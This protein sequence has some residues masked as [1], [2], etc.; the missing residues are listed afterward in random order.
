M[1]TSRYFDAFGAN[2]RIDTDIEIVAS[3]ED[4]N[5]YIEKCIQE[6]PRLARWVTSDI[7]LQVMIERKVTEAAQKMYVPSSCKHQRPVMCSSRV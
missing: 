4:I 2:M 6:T 1:V 3:D 5:K 7:Q